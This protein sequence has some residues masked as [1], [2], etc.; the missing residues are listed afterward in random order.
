MH[1]TVPS[2]RFNEWDLSK[3]H[4]SLGH[5]LQGHKATS[6]VRESARA[7]NKVSWFKRVKA[8]PLLFNVQELDNFRTKPYFS[9]I[10]GEYLT[11]RNGIFVHLVAWAPPLSWSTN[12][13]SGRHW[14]RLWRAPGLSRPPSPPEKWQMSQDQGSQ[15][16][17]WG[18][19]PPQAMTQRG[20]SAVDFVQTMS[21]QKWHRNLTH[22]LNQVYAT[23]PDPAEKKV[24]SF[25]STAY[26][27]PLVALALEE[28][29]TVFELEE[30]ETNL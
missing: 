11:V 18:A 9:T 10:E 2:A 19:S 5:P 22:T 4:H 1:W 30:S 6:D 13:F 29:L 14:G 8:F 16:P 26:C 24:P 15:R 28:L 12:C 21:G 7:L 25:K 17:G 23:S 27:A 3:C 20:Q